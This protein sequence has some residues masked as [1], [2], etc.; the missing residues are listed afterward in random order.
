M[1]RWLPAA[2]ALAL[3]A[4]LGAALAQQPG[5]GGFGGPGGG[6]GG[7][8]GGMGGPGGGPGGGMQLAASNGFV[9]VLAF[10]T[11]YQYDATT[12]QLKK[13]VTIPRPGQTGP[14]GGAPAPTPPAAPDNGGG[15]TDGQSLFKAK[16]A[17][18][19]ALP[20]PASKTVEKWGVT[21]NRMIQV[22]RARISTTER[23]AIMQ[24][25]AG[26]AAQ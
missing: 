20:D 17:T 16:C 18:C 23:D 11:L 6:F 24:Y 19:H 8:G 21:V 26:V 22:R 5:G 2:G 9:Y 3:L 7:P 10:G 13:Q 1:R 25:L 12:L 14:A 4:A 15:A